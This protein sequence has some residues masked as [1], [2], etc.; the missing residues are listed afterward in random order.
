MRALCRGGWPVES[1]KEADDA[2]QDADLHS[3]CWC[4]LDEL[5][6]ALQG[7]V[8]W[9]TVAEQATS[10][11]GAADTRP[12]QPPLTIVKVAD[13]VRQETFAQVVRECER[14]AL[15]Q[16]ALGTPVRI[17]FAFDN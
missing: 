5:T 12:A 1:T 7:D 4:T 14:L 10:E 16:Q 2:W 13:F 3:H 8:M 6:D 15:L 17:L 9:E 11:E